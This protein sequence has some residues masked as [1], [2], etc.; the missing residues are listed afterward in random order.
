MFST[1]NISMGLTG[2]I[3][4]VLGSL[5]ISKPGPIL[6]SLSWLVGIFI[7]CSGLTRF[8]SWAHNR[9]QGF[10][11][12]VLF[13]GLFQILLGALFIRYRAILT[14]TF[15]IGLIVVGVFYFLALFGIAHF[16][17]R[18]WKSSGNGGFG[19]FHHSSEDSEPEEIE[20]KSTVDRGSEWIDEQ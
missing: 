5:C 8:I 16:E 7:V 3:L 4:I 14:S 2:L 19:G 12:S 18:V 17:H 9:A 1:K 13:S 15:G 10:G 20:I 6:L 11:G